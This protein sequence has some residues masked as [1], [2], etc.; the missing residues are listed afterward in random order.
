[1]TTVRDLPDDVAKLYLQLRLTMDEGYTPSVRELAEQF[2]CST[3]TITTRIRVL[4]AAGLIERVRGK[5]R[6]LRLVR[7]A[8]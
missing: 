8:A 4:I 7:G 2:D 3:G 1:M 6:A 5:N